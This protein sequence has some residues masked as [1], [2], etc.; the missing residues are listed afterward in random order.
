M[1]RL[2]AGVGRAPFDIP[3]LPQSG[4][5]TPLVARALTLDDGDKR[6]CIVSGTYLGLF[7]ADA[8][9]VKQAVCEATGLGP[10]QTLIAGT[11]IHSGAPTL[12][13]DTD[14]RQLV[15]S[16][17]ARAC[18][19]AA[20][21]SQE[22]RPAR[23]GYA[24]DH[25]PGVSRVR[26]VLRTDGGVVTLRRAWPQYWGWATDP[27]TVGPEEELDDLLTVVRVEDDE[28]EPFAAIM[29]F[30]SHPI[31]DFFGW[32]ALLV[33][34]N[35]PGLTCLI[36]NGCFGSVDTPFEVPMRGRTQADQLPI[37][38]DILGYRTLDLLARAETTEQVRL[39]SA[40]RSVFLPFDPRFAESPMS[41][42]DIW[43]ELVARGGLDA[44]VVCVALGDLALAGIPGEAQ[45][46]FA[47]DI[48]RVSPYALTRG[49]G[50]AHQC[51]AYM[52]W[53]ESRARG[54]YEGDPMQWG[55]V[56]DEGLQVILDAIS[57]CLIE[58]RES[59]GMT[60]C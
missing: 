9:T 8:D 44:E 52:L 54:G 59:G 40:R 3:D 38:G 21:Q 27:E 29:H 2:R 12:T 20:R 4:D 39:A 37:L 30:T 6:F 19:E 41:R 22:L 53:P 51:C 1:E 24:T 28:G 16:R 35:V 57:E 43:A 46:G 48:E 45:V 18:A 31:P 11:H 55:M 7:G 33:E 47:R 49:V 50:N 58:M 26:R 15:V 5:G 36:L 14:K 13:G 42:T 34:R 32:A 17:I 56:A 23:L 60:G 25:L 10:E